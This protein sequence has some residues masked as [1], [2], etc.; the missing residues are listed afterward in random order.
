MPVA[1]GAQTF[2]LDTKKVVATTTLTVAYT[3]TEKTQIPTEKESLQAYA[4]TL[5]GDA[6]WKYFKYI[7]DKESSWKQANY[8][9]HYGDGSVHSATG[10]CGITRA[11]WAETGYERTEDP[12]K[13][14]HA[15]LGYAKS[16][17]GTL[18]RAYQHHVDNHWW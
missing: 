17:Y 7:I 16:R 4:K 9:Y 5:V 12:Y 8:G 11:S 6:D 18:Q 15:C 13:Q 3:E 2:N 1:L 10:L 14:I